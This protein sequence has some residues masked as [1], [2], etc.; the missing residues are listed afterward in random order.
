M[1]SQ[2]AD[3]VCMIKILS[4]PHVHTHIIPRQDSDLERTDDIY[5]LMDGEEGNVGGHQKEAQTQ[6]EQTQQRQQWQKQNEK[7]K[8]ALALEDSVRKPRSGEE[9]QKEAKWLSEE[10]TKQ[11]QI[12]ASSGSNNGGSR[13]VGRAGSS[14]L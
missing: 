12:D 2:K 1:L 3:V 9:M 10:M 7:H 13:A 11:E 8:Q 14:V 4:V 5:D 6:Q